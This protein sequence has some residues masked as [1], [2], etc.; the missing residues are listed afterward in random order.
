MSV[1]TLLASAQWLMFNNLWSQ[2]LATK[3]ALCP[4]D[5]Q[6]QLR[7]VSHG[8]RGHA[9][10]P[11]HVRS[12]TFAPIVTI[13]TGRRIVGTPKDPGH[14]AQPPH[15]HHDLHLLASVTFMTL[16]LLNFICVHYYYHLVSL[17]IMSIIFVLYFFCFVFL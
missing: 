11:E 9:S 1:T 10:F 17:A 16:T 4:G 12:V 15:H 3:P 6:G 14:P 7:Y 5:R 8:T 2:P 13:C